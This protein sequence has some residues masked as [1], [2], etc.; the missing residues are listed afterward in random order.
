MAV[1]DR[2]AGYW[3]KHGLDHIGIRQG[4]KIDTRELTACMVHKVVAFNLLL[5]KAREKTGD[6]DGLAVVID[7]ADVEEEQGH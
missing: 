1:D 3:L 7:L 6:L 4:E 2:V 5:R